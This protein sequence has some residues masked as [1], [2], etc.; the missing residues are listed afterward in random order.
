[1]HN[2]VSCFKRKTVDSVFQTDEIHFLKSYPVACIEPSLTRVLNHSIL[3]FTYTHLRYS[4]KINSNQNG[5]TNI[6]PF[7]L[8]NL[9][10][11]TGE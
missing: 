5:N 3:Y 2:S 6:T 10:F 4:V 11:L 7:S 8:N 1:M 9:P